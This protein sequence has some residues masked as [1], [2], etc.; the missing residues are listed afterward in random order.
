MALAADDTPILQICQQ[1]P[2][3]GFRSARLFA[4]GGTFGGESSSGRSM[5]GFPT[6][7]GIA[8]G[9]DGTLFTADFTTTVSRSL[10][11]TAIFLHRF[12]ET[13]RGPGRLVMRI[14]VAA[15]DGTVFVADF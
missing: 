7:N 2:H 15:D 11:P 14:A 13:G 8:T 10:R 4:A 1:R 12:G 5:A 3:P 6:V 9:P